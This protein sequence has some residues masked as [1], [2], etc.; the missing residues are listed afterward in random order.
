[1]KLF[2]FILRNFKKTVLFTSLIGVISGAA[3]AGLM[4]LIQRL[5][6]SEAQSNG[7]WAIAFVATSLLALAAGILS[8][9]LV[10]RLGEAINFDLRVRLSQQILHAPLRY[11]EEVGNDRLLTSLI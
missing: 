6:Y 2:F 10:I 11:L 1:M 4:I 3:S 9:V 5:L 8:Q 7:Q